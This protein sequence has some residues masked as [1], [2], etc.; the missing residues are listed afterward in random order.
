MR[1]E[2]VQ[3]LSRWL[4]ATD[5][6]LLELQGPGEHL[7]LRR[8]GT[9]VELVPS[10]TAGN[11]PES[12]VVAAA[13]VGVFLH[14]HPLRAEPLVPPGAVVGAGQVVGLLRIGALLLPVTAPQDGIL[15]AM[16]AEPGTI[17]GYGTPLVE[18]QSPGRQ[19]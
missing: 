13:S 2:E 10:D 17:V 4:E 1:I 5:I 11:E 9:R 14:G 18:L 19:A 3:Q 8:N 6:D 7:R 15:A 16:L 12:K